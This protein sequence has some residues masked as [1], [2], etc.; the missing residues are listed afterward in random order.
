[1]SITAKTRRIHSAGSAS[2]IL[3]RTP[4]LRMEEAALRREAVVRDRE[5]WTHTSKYF[6]TLKKQ[7]DRFESWNSDEVLRKR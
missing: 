4:K 2:S 7:T 6:D 3:H 5:F 1:M